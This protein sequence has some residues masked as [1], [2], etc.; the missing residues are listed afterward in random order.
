MLNSALWFHGQGQ[1]AKV[2]KINPRKSVP[3]MCKYGAFPLYIDRLCCYKM[4]AGVA[5]AV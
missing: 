2:K 3:N 4:G 1:S 5:Q